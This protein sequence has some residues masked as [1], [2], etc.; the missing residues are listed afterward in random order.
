MK[1]K[2]NLNY[3]FLALLA[4]VSN[5]CIAQI[6]NFSTCQEYFDNCSSGLITYYHN[7]KD[8]ENLCEHWLGSC[9]ENDLIYRFGA[10][11]IGGSPIL[12]STGFGIASCIPSGFLLSV[13]DGI[14]TDKITV[15]LCKNQWCDYVFEKDY[16]LL[17][18]F[19]VESFIEKN[20]HLPN[21]PSEK[22]IK[23]DEG[24]ELKEITIVQ[25]EKIEE[26]FLHLINL[27]KK[28]EELKKQLTAQRRQNLELRTSL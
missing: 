28:V 21:V 20:G 6:G 25:Q 4:F 12:P 22:E 1:I 17:P 15:E 5:I 19:E 2:I 16:N 14:A 26:A 9:S 13:N 8:K 18:L 10:V 7:N 11:N 27:E 23:K 24:F 3:C